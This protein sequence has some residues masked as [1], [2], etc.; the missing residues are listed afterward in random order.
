MEPGRRRCG[1]GS[2]DSGRAGPGITRQQRQHG[3]H[4]QARAAPGAWTRPRIAA[5]ILDCRQKIGGFEKIE[6]RLEILEPLRV[7]LRA[8]GQDIGSNR[9]EMS[10]EVAV[11]GSIV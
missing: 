7:A 11:D 2:G 9:Q 4:R 5:R 3:K 10:V 1:C 8:G 6:D